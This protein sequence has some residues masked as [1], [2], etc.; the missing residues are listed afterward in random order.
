M[1][2]PYF[3][4]TQHIQ[5]IHTKM[6]DAAALKVIRS[7]AK[8]Q[9][10]RAEKKLIDSLNVGEEAEKVPISTIKR[11]FQDASE[12][13]SKA[14]DAHDAYVANITVADEEQL[15]AEEQWIQ[16]ISDRFDR[17]E[18]SVDRYIDESEK[19]AKPA[20]A[21]IAIGANANKETNCMLKFDRIKLTLFG[22]DIRKFPRIQG[23]FY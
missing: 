7:T 23:N 14:Q 21:P 18:V 13:W 8:S 20:I 11:R 9:F 22:G 5:S 15:Q 3:L 16:E 17:L 10:T 12:R 6:A 19:A 2:Q 4:C 1:N